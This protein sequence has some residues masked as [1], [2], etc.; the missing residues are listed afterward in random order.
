MSWSCLVFEFAFSVGLEV[1][2]KCHEFVLILSTLILPEK[3]LDGTGWERGRGRFWSFHHFLQLSSGEGTGWGL[4]C[5]F[6][7]LY[8]CILYFGTLAFFVISSFGTLVFF[9]LFWLCSEGTG[10][11]GGEFWWWTDEV[12]PR[13]CVCG[14][15]ETS[16]KH[17]RN[18]EISAFE[19]LFSHWMS[20]NERC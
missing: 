7:F 9:R 8:F 3:V 17:P 13:K 1:Y 20:S 15:Q 4:F 12:S 18:N 14:P 6:I 16:F 10:W 2:K 5:N 11:G 19:N